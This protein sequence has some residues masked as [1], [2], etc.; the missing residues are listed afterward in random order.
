MAAECLVISASPGSEP[1]RAC[2]ENAVA[3]RCSAGGLDVLHI[4]HI[5]YLRRGGAVAAQLRALDGRIHLAAW[6]YPRAAQAIL[7]FLTQGRAAA[8]CYDLRDF[9]DAKSCAGTILANAG[10]NDGEGAVS[11]LVQKLDDRWYPVIDYARC[12]SC[13]KCLDFCLF[14]TYSRTDGKIVVSNP[15]NCKPGCP[16]CARICPKAAIIFPHCSQDAV[17]AGSPDDH[18]PTAEQPEH[19]QA[20]AAGAQS[21]D[22]QLD[23]LM[24]ALDEFDE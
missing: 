18:A 12:V 10:V 20:P 23:D 14:G 22:A 8:Q 7:G 19:A 11:D 17:I 13:G 16:A 9:A 6:L 21:A 1:D 15:D 5:Y 4:P 2:L 3:E 24:K